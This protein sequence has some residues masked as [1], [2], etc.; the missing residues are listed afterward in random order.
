MKVKRLTGNRGHAAKG[1]RAGTEPGPA[2]MRTYEA[3]GPNVELRDPGFWRERVST[4][5]RSGC[6]VDH[7]FTDSEME[8]VTLLLSFY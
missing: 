3:C 2:V 5:A 6:E 4:F 7:R 1:P 8:R